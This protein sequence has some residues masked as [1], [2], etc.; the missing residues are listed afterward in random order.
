MIKNLV[1]EYDIKHI[2]C[3]QKRNGKEAICIGSPYISDIIVIGMDGTLIKPYK[4]D[5]FYPNEELVRYMQE[6]T[7]DPEKLKRIVQ[8]K[9]TFENLTTVWIYE[10][11]RIFKKQCEEIGYPN[12]TTDGFLMYNNTTFETKKEALK[13]ARQSTAIEWRY[14]KE[15]I[16]WKRIKYFFESLAD[17]IFIRIIQPFKQ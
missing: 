17:F 3:V 9:D 10:N 1:K 5:S 15:V 4:T 2:V 6:F 12:T 7:A 11:R 13:Y 8:S 14:L 16:N